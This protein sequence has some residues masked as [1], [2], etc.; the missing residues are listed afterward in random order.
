[1]PRKELATVFL[2]V[3]FCSC[4]SRVCFRLLLIPKLC[5]LVPL[6]CVLPWAELSAARMLEKEHFVICG[7][8]LISSCDVF[9]VQSPS[10]LQQQ[11]TVGYFCCGG[12]SASFIDYREILPQ[13]V[14]TFRAEIVEK[15]NCGGDFCPLCIFQTA[16]HNNKKEAESLKRRNI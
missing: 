13:K 5:V 15:T 6:E 4:A 14:G 9:S 2:W 11:Q 1:M 10:P 16:G 12:M 8:R 3:C 7:S